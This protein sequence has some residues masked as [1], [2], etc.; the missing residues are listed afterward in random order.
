MLGDGSFASFISVTVD[1]LLE[2]EPDEVAEFILRFAAARE[3]LGNPALSEYTFGSTHA[4]KGFPPEKQTE[5]ALA[6]SEAWAWLVRECLLIPALGDANNA[7]VLSRRAQR[8]VESGEFSEFR[9]ERSLQ[10]A[11]LHIRLRKQPYSDFIRGDYDGAVFK[12]MRE[13]EIAV[14]EASGG[15]RSDVGVKLM[16]QAFH[17]TDTS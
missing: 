17:S 4:R 8:I 14:R 3:S 9:S 6:L 15:S 1:D 13:V 16:R 12:A 2:L 10:R 11:Q 7:F 5:V